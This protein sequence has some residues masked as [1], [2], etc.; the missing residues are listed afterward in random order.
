MASIEPGYYTIREIFKVAGFDLNQAASVDY[1]DGVDRRKVK[2]G[3]V[4]FDDLEDMVLIP[5]SADTLEISV[6]GV[7]SV[8]LDVVED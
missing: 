3:G 4:G 6:D 5:S 1:G 8:T 2:V 7:P